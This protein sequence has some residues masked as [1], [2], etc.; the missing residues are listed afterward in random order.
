MLTQ[1]RV[2]EL[3][4]YDEETGDLIRKV[5]KVSNQTNVGEIVGSISN[6]GYLQLSIDRTTYLAHRVAWLYTYGYLPENQIDH[7]NQIKTDNKLNNLREVS[8]QCNVRN[9]GN[10]GDNTSGVKGVCWNKRNSKWMVCINNLGVSLYQGLHTDFTEAVAHRLAAEQALKWEGCE[11]SSP[12][13][14]YIK[15]YLEEVRA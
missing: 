2:K 12:A 5:V 11:L 1:E 10:R 3:F 4:D 15:E 8:R 7:I 6:Y 14:L 13:F 9:T